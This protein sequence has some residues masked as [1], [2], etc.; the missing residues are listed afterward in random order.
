MKLLIKDALP[1]HSCK[2]KFRIINSE[3]YYYNFL[4]LQGQTG[5][6]SKQYKLTKDFKTPFPTVVMQW[7]WNMVNS[8]QSTEWCEHAPHHLIKS[9][10]LPLTHCLLWRFSCPSLASVS[11]SL[12]RRGHWKPLGKRLRN[13]NQGPGNKTGYQ[14]EWTAAAAGGDCSIVAEVENSRYFP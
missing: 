13:W 10:V 3:S 14:R 7:N 6:E 1:L 2:K 12:N 8:A 5:S 9:L 11:L 4:N